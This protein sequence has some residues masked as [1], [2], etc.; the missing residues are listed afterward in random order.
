[1]AKRMRLLVLTVLVLL[2]SGVSFLVTLTACSLIDSSGTYTL[3]SSV[4]GAPFTYYFGSYST[5][6]LVNASNVVIDCQGNSIDGRLSSGIV[7]LSSTNLTVKNCV[8]TGN[9]G[10][11]IL[12]LANGTITNNTF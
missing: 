1:M 8:L 3:N 2:V 6:M 5:C 12:G 7:P 9:I 4:S 11:D 10:I